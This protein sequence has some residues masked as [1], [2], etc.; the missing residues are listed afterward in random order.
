MLLDESEPILR[1]TGG[2]VDERY[3]LVVEVPDVF[4]TLLGFAPP[5]AMA[6]AFDA[7]V[8][9]EKGFVN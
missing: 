9:F 4:Y 2:R 3:F 5:A 6:A 7:E 1:M 8:S